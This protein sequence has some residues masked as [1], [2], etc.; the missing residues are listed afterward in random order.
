MRKEG[1]AKPYEGFDV[2]GMSLPSLSHTNMTSPSRTQTG[3]TERALCHGRLGRSAAADPL[4]GAG[5]CS[6][7]AA[8]RQDWPRA[9]VVEAVAGKL[10][11][12]WVRFLGSDISDFM[13]RV[14]FLFIPDMQVWESPA[15]LRGFMGVGLL[16]IDLQSVKFL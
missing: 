11:A 13:S 16:Q 7:V 10:H 12:W 5:S 1:L 9:E 3:R 4:L 15:L 2:W 6:F 8:R 14:S